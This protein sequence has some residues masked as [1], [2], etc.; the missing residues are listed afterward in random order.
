MQ[1]ASEQASPWRRVGVTLLVVVAALAV[2]WAVTAARG[3]EDLV[4]WTQDFQAAQARAQ[5]QGK[6]MLVNFTADWC[7]PCQQMNR[8]VY[9]QPDVADA[10]ATRFIAVKV[11]FTSPGAAQDA[12]ARQLG[13]AGS[14]PTR[15]IVAPDG[16]PV[17]R[18]I[19]SVPAAELLDWLERAGS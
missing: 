3:G 8:Q 9:S 1:H 19:G 18:Q 16:Q 17:S 6:P 11:D 10:I 5:A 4:G 14:L 12:V 13:F 7:G 15:M 2:M